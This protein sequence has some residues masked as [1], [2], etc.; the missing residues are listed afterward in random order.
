MWCPSG[1][2]K[3]AVLLHQRFSHNQVEHKAQKKIVI[4]R[5]EF[6]QLAQFFMLSL[7]LKISKESSLVVQYNRLSLLMSYHSSNRDEQ[8]TTLLPLQLSFARLLEWEVL[9]QLTAMTA[10]C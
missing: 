10:R 2:F 8:T 9:F 5:V 6:F 3:C 4:G 1:C 7:A